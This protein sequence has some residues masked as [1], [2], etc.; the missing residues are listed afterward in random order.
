MNDI[1]T[2]PVN[3]VCIE[4]TVD[5][6]ISATLEECHVMMIVELQVSASELEHYFCK[7]VVGKIGTAHYGLYVTAKHIPTCRQ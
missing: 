5:E 7:P 6:N 1:E 3:V 2:I 4:S